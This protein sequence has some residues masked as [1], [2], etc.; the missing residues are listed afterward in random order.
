MKQISKSLFAVLV[1]CL[2]L[3]Y[4]PVASAHKPSDSYLVLQMGG[5]IMKG[6]WDIALRDLEYALGIDTDNNREI[7]WGE[8]RSSHDRIADYAF[9]RLMVRSSSDNPCILTPMNQL[10][11]DRHSDG[12]YAVLRFILDCPGTSDVHSLDYDL[13]FDLD[14]SHRGLLRIDYPSTVQTAVLSP[15]RPRIELDP[16]TRSSARQFAE[17]WWEGIVHIAIGYDHILFLLTLLLPAA[18]WRQNGRWRGLDS[19]RSVLSEA[20]AIVTAFTI[21]HSI[22]LSAAAS[23]SI[24]VPS[25]WVESAIAATVLLVALN[26]LYPLASGRRWLLAFCLGLIHGFGFASVLRDLGLPS[27]TLMLALLGFNLGVETGQLAMVAAFLPIAF[28]FRGTPFYHRIVVPF[29]SATVAAV[30]MLWML[31]RSI[32]FEYLEI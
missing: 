9:S 12:A 19:F 22:T 18:L 26:N 27:E 8:L 29:G 24:V 28:L 10:M 2:L 21:A 20:A 32:G 1:A 14:P 16:I 4:L 13:F 31:Q 3:L 5:E 30:A 11:V 25:R 7:T 23:G 15:D 6:Q 17:Y